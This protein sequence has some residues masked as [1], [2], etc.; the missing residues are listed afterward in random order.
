MKKTPIILSLSALA[1]AS[2]GAANIVILS[3]DVDVYK[4]NGATG[5]DPNGS[6][7]TTPSRFSG[8]TGTD[9]IRAQIQTAIDGGDPNL[10]QNTH[11]DTL[12]TEGET[13]NPTQNDN[14]RLS[15]RGSF[16][17]DDMDG[18][19]GEMIDLTFTLRSDDGSQFRIFGQDF[20]GTA[21]DSRT[22]IEDIDGDG[23]LTADF[24][25]GNTNALGHI[26]LTEGILYQFDSYMYEGGGGSR[27]ELQ[28][29]LGTKTSFD[30]DFFILDS[31]GFVPE[32]SSFA[33]AAL[34]LL[35]LGMRRHR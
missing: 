26:Q 14:Y 34:G 28:V 5:V 21:G 12:I 24:F 2:S 15:V 4:L 20:T 17:V 7:A 27:Y 8:P 18:T 35:S 23:A 22:F 6:E 3:G 16:M 29:A 32:P 19:P 33:L 1:I 9:G 11:P 25:T 31:V 13:P 30:T 10:N